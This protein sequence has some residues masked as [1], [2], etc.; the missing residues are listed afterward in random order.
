MELGINIY[1][2]LKFHHYYPIIVPNDESYF[3]WQT[4]S[5]S[6]FYW[7][8]AMKLNFHICII[9]LQRAEI[10]GPL[11][12]DLENLKTQRNTTIL[13]KSPCVAI[14]TFE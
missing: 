4:L 8:E 10:F 7:T 1:D 2:Q 5:P 11:N 12:G 9:I 13:K 3:Y 14:G 6:L